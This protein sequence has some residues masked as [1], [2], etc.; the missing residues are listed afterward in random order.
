MTEKRKGK[1]LRLSAEE[2]DLIY[3]FRGTDIDNINGNTALDL[4]LQE[5]GI[6]KKRCC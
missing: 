2:A 4:H 6:N 1:R 5:R 3:E